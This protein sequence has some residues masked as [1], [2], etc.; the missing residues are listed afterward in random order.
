M[1]FSLGRLMAT[2]GAIEHLAEHDLTPLH[3]IDR[4]ST[5]DWGDLGVSDKK[6]NDQAITDGS[7]ILSAYIVA[8][9]KLYVIT[10]SDRS[11]TTVLLASEY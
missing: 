3:L 10:E 9:E 1:L 4:H 6:L 8:G 5:G 7:R 11:Y 2:P